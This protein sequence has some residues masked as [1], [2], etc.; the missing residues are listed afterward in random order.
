MTNRTF[1]CFCT[2]V[3]LS[4]VTGCSSDPPNPADRT[5]TDAG[6][7]TLADASEPVGNDAGQPPSDASPAIPD[8]SRDGGR[9]AGVQADAAP[10][11]GAGNDA[12]AA[13]PDAGSPVLE[14]G[15]PVTVT[16]GSCTTATSCWMIVDP[17]NADV[18]TMCTF[19]SGTFASTSCP[20]AGYVRKCTQTLNGSPGGR[21]TWVY[22]FKAGDPVRCL[23]VEESLPGT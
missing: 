14:A 1:L 12:A 2:S 13:R 17:P 4:L 23:G 9:D 3:L 21:Q 15:S 6:P 18:R 10:S 11:Q 8:A 20:T 5:D 7:E 22:Y 16:N 19:A